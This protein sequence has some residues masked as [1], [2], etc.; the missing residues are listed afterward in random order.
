MPPPTQMA[1]DRSKLLR[2]GPQQSPTSPTPRTATPIATANAFC[3]SA[4]A[5]ADFGDR[6]TRDGGDCDGNAGVPRA[7]PYNRD[8]H[9]TLGSLSP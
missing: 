7:S 4:C 8:R 2:K 1:R 3:S 6:H 9:S 5:A